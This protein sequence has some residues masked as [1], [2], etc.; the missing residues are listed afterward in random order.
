MKNTSKSIMFDNPNARDWLKEQLKNQ[1][2]TVFFEKKDGTMREMNCTL[3][4]DLIQPYER[5][6]NSAPKRQ[7]NDVL[8]VFD[9]SKN[10]WRSF[11]F[12]S[13]RE[14]YF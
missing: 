8:P 12:D 14:I 3:K 6:E 13:I 10:E 4:E 2:V 11:R 9:L 1:T 5:K 7:N